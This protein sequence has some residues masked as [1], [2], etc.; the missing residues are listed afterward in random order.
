M[1]NPTEFLSQVTAFADQHHM[2]PPGTTVLCALSGG[3]DSMALLSL[4]LDLAPERQLTVLAAHYNHQLRGEEAQ[5][6]E[7]FVSGYCRDRGIPCILGRGDVAGEARRRKRGIEE[8]ARAM[9]YDFLLETA[10]AQGAQAVATAHNADDNGETILLH[11][12]RGTGLDGLTGIPPK[13]GPLIRPLLT[14]P[15]QA[16]DAYL[17][18]R[19]I[20]HVED[21]SNQDLSYAR[22]RIRQEV[23]PV[24][25]GLNPAFSSTLAA[26]LSHL[27]KDRDY[28]D[29]LAEEALVEA[30]QEGTCLSLPA[31]T[32]ENLPQ[33]VAVRAVK[34]ALARLG[35]H[36]S[37][38]V[39]LQAILDLARQPN[40]SARLSLPQGLE[41]ARTYD[42]LRLTLSP[43]ECPAFSPLTLREEGTY[44]L[45]HGWTLTLQQLP[46]PPAPVQGPWDC[47]LSR[48]A[49]TFPLTVRPRQTGDRLRLPGRPEKALKKWYIDEKI[50]RHLRDSLPV[51][52]DSRGLLAAAGLGPQESRLAVPG[53]PA[54]SLRVTPPK[55]EP[56]NEERT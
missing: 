29:Q 23:M 10:K 32:L 18:Q 4:L 22:N 25:R 51:L 33:P 15:R 13:R 44:V 39:H 54:F 53:E 56:K 52:T 38:A 50:P 28:L 49:V 26:S 6:D 14:T 12:V 35:R 19:N 55:Q 41:A 21:S 8:T 9:R 47:W 2:L 16:I 36:E 27:R 34:H 11:L 3:G 24:L 7:A 43:P 31:Q 46:C 37:S 48:S 17:A 45:S 20:P 42:A 5:R 1:K 30:T 40:P